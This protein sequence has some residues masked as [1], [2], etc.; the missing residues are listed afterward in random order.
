M[1][2]LLHAGAIND[3][4]QGNVGIVILAKNGDLNKQLIY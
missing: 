1:H 2:N 3:G 4:P